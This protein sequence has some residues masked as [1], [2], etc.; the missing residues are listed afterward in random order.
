EASSKKTITAPSSSCS[1]RT[2]VA[3]SS[4]SRSINASTRLDGSPMATN[5]AGPRRRVRVEV[6]MASPHITWSVPRVDD[7][8]YQRF[9]GVLMNDS[10][11]M[12]QSRE[13]YQTFRDD[14]R[15]I[16]PRRLE[17]RAAG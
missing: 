13:L 10:L 16:F 6:T 7:S 2:A 14:C 8:H 4:S 11:I 9:L 5:W 3:P 12:E 17:A 1:T 15:S